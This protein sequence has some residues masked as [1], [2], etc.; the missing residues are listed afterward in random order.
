MNGRRVA[1]Q[2]AGASVKRSH[3][4]ESKTSRHLVDQR[5]A[6][7]CE[8][9]ERERVPNALAAKADCGSIACNHTC[10][11]AG[12]RR[13]EQPVTTACL[14]KQMPNDSVNH[15]AQRLDVCPPP[16]LESRGHCSSQQRRVFP[17]G[18]APGSNRWRRQP[19]RHPRQLVASRR[20]F[21]SLHMAEW[22][23]AKSAR[24]ILTGDAA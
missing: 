1:Q 7:S 19:C 12:A 13:D 5:T 6:N 16:S 14:H 4:A 21:P 18:S 15:I 23:Q 9:S 11:A 8:M 2:P 20:C 24:G 17:R 22:C 10:T 3:R